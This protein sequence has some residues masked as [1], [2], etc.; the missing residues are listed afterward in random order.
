[1]KVF[2]L[3]ILYMITILKDK[4]E[5]KDIYFLGKCI[6]NIML[7][8]QALELGSTLSATELMDIATVCEVTDKVKAYDSDEIS[9]SLSS[10]FSL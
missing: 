3:N 10:R 4:I 5:K 7:S 9:D 8:L 2:Q 1:M 6:K